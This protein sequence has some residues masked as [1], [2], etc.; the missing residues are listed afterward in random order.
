MDA[1]LAVE[2]LGRC[3]QRRK[4]A[5]HGGRGLVIRRAIAVAAGLRR[6]LS[7]PLGIH[8]VADQAEVADLDAAAD[9]QQVFRLD[10]Q[11]LQGELLPHVVERLRG[12]AEMGEQFVARDSRQARSGGIPRSGL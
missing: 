3:V 2:Q 6:R 7:V 1:G 4:A 12:I 9:D 5:Q 10:V 8:D 11:V